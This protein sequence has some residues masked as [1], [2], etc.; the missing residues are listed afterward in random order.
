MAG[1]VIC[2]AGP[3]I[4]LACVDRLDLMPR[5]FGEVWIPPAVRSECLA[6]AGADRDR[7]EAALQETWLRVHTPQSEC[8]P[9]SPSLGAGETE[10]I[11]LALEDPGSLLVADDRLARRYALSRG[12]AIVGT[13]R[14]LWI[15]EQKGLIDDAA[16]IVQAMAE[17]GYRISIELL[18]HVR[19]GD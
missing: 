5:L 19:S 15:A 1:R 14:L 18:E 9:I 12:I 10:G 3:L 4:A 6:G 17:V 13:V 16:Q 7:I 2:D 8:T 11:Y